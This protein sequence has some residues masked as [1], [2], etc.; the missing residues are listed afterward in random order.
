MNSSRGCNRVKLKD[1]VILFVLLFFLLVIVTL[2][3]ELRNLASE[4]LR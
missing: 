2:F 1:M 4:G 3:V